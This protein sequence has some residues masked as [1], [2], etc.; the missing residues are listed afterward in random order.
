MLVQV[1][2]N[3]GF[4]VRQFLRARRALL[5]HFNTPMSRHETG[6]PSDLR[7]A[8][9]LKDTP[10]CFSTIQVGDRGPGQVIGNWNQA[11]AGGS[12]GLVVDV[13]EASIVAVGPGDDG[14]DTRGSVIQTG[15]KPPTAQSCAESI[16]KRVD[17]DGR[18]NDAANEWLVKNYIILGIFIFPNP[19]VWTRVG[20]D[21]PCSL[22]QVLQA[23]PQERVFGVDASTF[24]ELDKQSGAWRSATYDQI[25]PA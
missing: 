11:N 13:T 6:F 15:G 5:V 3:I 4:S 12:V 18:K 17:P 24:L 2:A 20:G 7:D 23:F 9:S 1:P 21:Q 19:H 14:S 8:M 16:D 10:A 25:V 22:L